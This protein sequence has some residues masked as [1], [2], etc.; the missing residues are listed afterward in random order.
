MTS[1]SFARARAVMTGFLNYLDDAIANI[2]LDV[3][4]K[5]TTRQRQNAGRIRATGIE[6]E[7]D[8]RP[9]PELTVNAL[10]AF[11]T[12]RFRDAPRL[13]NLRGNRVPQVPRYQLGAGFGYTDPKTLT[14][15]AQFRI[16]G[17]QF[18]DDL[19]ERRLDNYTIVDIQ[20]S[21]VI[22]Q[23][24]HAFIGCENLLDVEYD[25]GLSGVRRIGLP[26]TIHGGLRLFLP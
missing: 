23:G 16:V 2:T 13:P 7:T 26:R 10:A 25:I 4:P 17:E 15:S 8:I 24:V 18:D 1:P 5:L 22:A 20:A 3:T 11:T 9:I 6:I 14:L 21:R 12:S 19:N